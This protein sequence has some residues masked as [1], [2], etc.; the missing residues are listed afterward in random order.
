MKTE[1][2]DLALTS[3]VRAHLSELSGRLTGKDE[4]I[5]R[6]EATGVPARLAEGVR[7]RREGRE[8]LPHNRF[9]RA[10]STWRTVRRLL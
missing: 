4:A 10:A 7:A 1:Y 8:A 6:L 3:V 9:L 2:V 5:G